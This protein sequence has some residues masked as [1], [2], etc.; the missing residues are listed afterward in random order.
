M[1][2]TTRRHL[3]LH[4]LLD[5]LERAHLDLAHPFA[6][7]LVVLGQVFQR[8]RFLVQATFHK[9]VPLTFVQRVERLAEQGS[10]AAARELQ[11]E[12]MDAAGAR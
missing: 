11:V 12:V 9:D 10:L 3:G 2:Q 4:G 8:G 6:R 5:F 1:F 7:D